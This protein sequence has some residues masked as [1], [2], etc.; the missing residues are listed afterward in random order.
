MFYIIDSLCFLFI[1]YFYLLYIEEIK[2]DNSI[3]LLRYFLNNFNTRNR[4]IA[5]IYYGKYETFCPCIIS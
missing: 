3:L 1:I 5:L 4:K 2:N